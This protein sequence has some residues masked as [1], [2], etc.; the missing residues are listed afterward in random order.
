MYKR[1]EEDH[2]Q[3]P[4]LCVQKYG[5]VGADLLALQK[6]YEVIVD[7]GGQDSVELRQ[8]IAVADQWIIPVRP[9]QLDLVAMTKMRQLRRDVFNRVGQAPA[10]S[11][12]LNAV[13]AATKEGEE[14]RALLNE[15]NDELGEEEG[16]RMIVMDS[17][18][19]DRVSVRRAMRFGCAVVELPSKESSN[20]ALTEIGAVYKEVFGEAYEPDQE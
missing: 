18:M 8:S 20:A 7:A 1:Q 10:T 6:V 3:P 2:N 14:A 17:M 9:G 13:S 12:L 4:L 15:E 11:V 16:G 5:K 19:I